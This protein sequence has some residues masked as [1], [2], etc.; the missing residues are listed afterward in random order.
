MLSPLQLPVVLG[1][2]IGP[3]VL[4]RATHDDVDGVMALFADDAISAAR[5][6]RLDPG[7]REAYAAGVRAVLEDARNDLVV[8]ELGGRVV[9]M[10]QLTLIPGI[11]RL[12][13]ERLQLEGVR[14]AADLRSTGI[15]TAMVRWAIEVA[16]PALGASLVQLTSDSRRTEARRFYERLGFAVSHTGFKLRVP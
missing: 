4:R 10:Q 2:R 15:G 14:V 3:A 1:A 8:V 7:D 11:A 6:D 13:A 16:A 5:G 12:G 9:G